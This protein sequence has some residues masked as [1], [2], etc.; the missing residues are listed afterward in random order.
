MCEDV[1]FSRDKS[2]FRRDHE[3]VTYKGKRK[4]RERGSRFIIV[5][6]STWLRR[7]IDNQEREN[8]K[9]AR[10]K[11][12]I[13]DSW[14]KKITN[15][16]AHQRASRKYTRLRRE[17]DRDE[18]NREVQR[19]VHSTEKIGQYGSYE[20]ARTTR[21]K[22]LRG[23]YHEDSKKKKKVTKIRSRPFQDNYEERARVER[24]RRRIWCG[25]IINLID[26]NLSDKKLIYLQS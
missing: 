17:D 19:A 24:R 10:N 25:R 1:N 5:P 2:E 8:R 23:R 16:N 18:Y 26:D 11:N 4:E 20:D 22:H 12:L 3:R 9:S 14:L 15:K 6:K 13:S 21:Q 7:Q